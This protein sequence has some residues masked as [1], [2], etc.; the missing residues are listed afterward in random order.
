MNRTRRTLSGREQVHGA[1]A[2][3][4]RSSSQ[5][6]PEA[7]ATPPTLVQSPRTVP[8]T[9]TTRPRRVSAVVRRADRPEDLGLFAEAAGGGRCSRRWRRPRCSLRLRAPSCAFVHVFVHIFAPPADGRGAQDGPWHGA[10]GASGDPGWLPRARGVRA[11]HHDGP[12]GAPSGYVCPQC[13]GALW[14]R[15]GG[16]GAPA[17]LGRRG[18]G[19]RLR[20][21]SERMAAGSA[22]AEP[23]VRRGTASVGRGRCCGRWRANDEGSTAG[24][25]SLSRR[26]DR[27][28]LTGCFKSP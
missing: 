22:P 4:H 10:C 20:G 17:V 7:D 12:P 1:R 9:A 8:G 28:W 18:R 3:C 24:A 27:N 21:G 23:V 15:L 11:M 6:V 13:G 16:D 5:S 25:V 2:S 14:E 19:H 26:L